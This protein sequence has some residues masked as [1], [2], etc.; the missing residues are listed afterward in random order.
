[1]GNIWVISLVLTHPHIC[2]VKQMEAYALLFRRS[3]LFFGTLWKAN[4]AIE[5]HHPQQ[6][7]QLSCSAIFN[8]YVSLPEGIFP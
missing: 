5:N 8:S 1:M 6:V 3:H 4:I 2:F 7:K